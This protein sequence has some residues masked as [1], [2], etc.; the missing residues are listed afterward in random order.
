[1]PDKRLFEIKELWK[2]AGKERDESVAA[3]RRLPGV[4]DYPAEPTR[5]FV[6]PAH[7]ICADGN[8]GA[9]PGGTAAR[10]PFS[11]CNQGRSDVV[12]LGS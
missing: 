8:A 12:E 6:S 3:R 9:G 4:V 5:I 7:D 1:V 10:A 11:A 2:N